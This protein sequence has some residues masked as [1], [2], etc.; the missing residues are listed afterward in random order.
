M[1]YALSDFFKVWD[2]SEKTTSKPVVALIPDEYFFFDD[3]KLPKGALQKEEINSMAQ[4]AIENICP[5]NKEKIFSGFFTNQTNSCVTIF[6]ASKNRILAEIPDLKT[7][8]YWLPERFCRESTNGATITK[9]DEKCTTINVSED[10]SLEVQG[11]KLDLFSED[12]WSAEMHEQQ[13]KSIARKVEKLNSWY[14]KII[15]PLVSVTSILFMLVVIL[16]LGRSSIKLRYSILEKRESRITQ[17]IERKNLYDEIRIFSEG[18]ALYFK[19]LNAINKIRPAQLFFNQFT[20]SNPN[21]MKFIGICNSVTTLNLF[22]ENLKEEPSIHT[23]SAPRISSS[24]KGT[25]FHLE[26]EYLQL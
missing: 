4:T 1:G 22:L 10:G 11:N 19:R 13:E 21:V 6:L 9:T 15:F 12:F 18:K 26:V 8:T 24:S 3:I 25:T 2:L 20:M 5:V 14:K 23:V 7:F 16:M 17:I